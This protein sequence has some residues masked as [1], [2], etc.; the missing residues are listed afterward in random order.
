MNLRREPYTKEGIKKV[1]CFRCGAEASRQIC[2]HS[3][4]D[5]YRPTCA[6]CDVKL[7][8]LALRFMGFKNW[9]EKIKRY[10]KRMALEE[11]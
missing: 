10:K 5:V 7:H 6:E 3:D 9:K 1:K 8:S 2:L 11:D 4:E